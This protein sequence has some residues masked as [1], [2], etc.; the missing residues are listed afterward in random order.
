MNL[1]KLAQHLTIDMIPSLPEK[2]LANFIE[3]GVIEFIWNFWYG[4]P[5]PKKELITITN[6]LILLDKDPPTTN[7]Y[8]TLSDLDKQIPKTY[9]DIQKALIIMEGKKLVETGKNW[10]TKQGN[11]RFI[12]LTFIGRDAIGSCKLFASTQLKE[13]EKKLLKSKEAQT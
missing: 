10:E 3:I 6:I 12:K 11:R 8:W 9:A 5:L 13:L 1:E 4:D 2:E 7:N